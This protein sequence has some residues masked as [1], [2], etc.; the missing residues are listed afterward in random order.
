MQIKVGVKFAGIIIV[1][2]STVAILA[3]SS[4][5]SMFNQLLGLSDDETVVQALSTARQ[6]LADMHQ[7]R[8]DYVSTVFKNC[9]NVNECKLRY[10]Y[11][12]FSADL[13]ENDTWI[14]SNN[15][16][17]K[18]GDKA[19]RFEIEWKDIKADFK[20]L[21]DLIGT[22]DHFN[23][24]LPE[25]LASHARLLGLSLAV[26]VLLA[27][28]LTYLLSRSLARR[29]NGLI[30]YTKDIGRGVLKRPPTYAVGNDELGHLA[31][32]MNNMA[33]ELEKTRQKLIMSE[34]MASWQTV[35]RKVAHEIKNPLTP[36]SL[37][38]DQLRS[39]PEMSK[40]KL[41]SFLQQSAKVIEEETGSLQ[42]MVREFSG[43]ASLPRPEP[44]VEN[45]ATIVKDFIE[46]NTRA[47]GPILLFT[48][49]EAD[50]A[51]LVDRGMIFQV[52]HNLCN[53]ARLAKHPETVT[54]QMSLKSEKGILCVEVCDNGPGIPE[55]M[56][57]VLFEAYTTTRSTGD[58]EKGM[59]LGLAISRK[60]LFDHN[61]FLELKRTSDK[62]ACFELGLPKINEVKRS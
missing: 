26:S 39:L 46:R 33:E 23:Y 56:H 25:I 6:N 10:P 5:L 49:E 16:V 2:M 12:V 61:G 14:D 43:F 21:T 60:I 52:L 19:Y 17:V 27:L 53:N 24:L 20:G 3:Y 57:H 37:I 54:V 59:G 18:L 51:C 13:S 58:G 4:S 48:Q 40:D 31:L 28:G 35:A 62:G 22:R 15:Y 47:G 29:L 45:L 36:I 41:Q 7:V 50:Y 38:A 55:L 8:Q 34:K 9:Q 42:R 32:A 1:T 11:K 44:K 30:E